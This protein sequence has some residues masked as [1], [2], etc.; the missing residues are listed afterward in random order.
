MAKIKWWGKTLRVLEIIS[1]GITA[2]FTLMAGIGTTCVAVAAKNF[3][4]KMAAIAP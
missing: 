1:M 2:V 4:P 3:G